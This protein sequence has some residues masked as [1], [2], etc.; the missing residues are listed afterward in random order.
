MR[1]GGIGESNGGTEFK[2]VV[3]DT[4]LRTFVNVT[5]YPYPAQ[6]LKKKR[7]L[8]KI[9]PEEGSISRPLD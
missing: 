9:T 8:K 4:L 5:M 7:N 6:Q 3:F 1:G 2:H